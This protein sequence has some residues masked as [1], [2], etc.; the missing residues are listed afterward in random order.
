MKKFF[1]PLLLTLTALVGGGVVAGSYFAKEA[2]VSKGET[3][4]N[5]VLDPFVSSLYGEEAK[6][7]V[8]YTIASEDK[9][10]YVQQAFA[11][12]F[13]DDEKVIVT[14]ELDLTA[15]QVSSIFFDGNLPVR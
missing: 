14:R 11:V 3:V 9:K 6:G 5:D 8:T 7:S 4:D 15:E 12:K 1:T 13:T 2:I 10:G